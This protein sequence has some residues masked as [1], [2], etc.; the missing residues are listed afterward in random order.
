MVL[1]ALLLALY[2]DREANGK[3]ALE[4]WRDEVTAVR[5]IAADLNAVNQG[6]KKALGAAVHGSLERFGGVDQPVLVTEALV[7]AAMAAQ[8]FPSEDKQRRIDKLTR[9]NQHLALIQG[10]LWTAIAALLVVLLITL[11]FLQRLRRSRKEIQ[12]LNVSLD[13]QVQARTAEL[14]QQASYLRTLIDTLPVAVWLKDAEGRYLAVNATHNSLNGQTE[15]QMIGQT[16][17]EL[18]PGPI[19]ERLGEADLEVMATRQRLSTETV[20]PDQSGVPL[21]REIDKAP[22]LDEDGTLLGT[23]GVSH[24]ISER[25][26]AE[27]KLKQA[28]EFSEGVINA[29]PDL[30]F[31]M[32]ING[33]YLNVW[34]HTP[35]LLAGQ[36][37]MLLGKTVNEVLSPESAE[38]FM[39]TLSEAESDGLSFGKVIRNDLPQGERWFELSVSK[40]QGGTDSESTFLVLSRDIT[41]RIRLETELLDSRNFLDR[42]IDAVP[43]PIFVKDRKH[44]WVLLNEAY[45]KLSGQQREVLLGKSDY[46]FFP[47]EEAEVFWEKD[48]LVFESGEINLNEERFTSVHGKQHFIQTKKTPFI[49]ADGRKMLVGV[50]RDIT[51]RKSYEEAREAALEEARLLARSRSEF[52]AKMSHELR[53]PLNSILGFAQVLIQDR[54]L[55]EEY[56]S[57][58]SIIQ[59]SGE[60][61]LT[62]INDILDLAKS[63]AGRTEL[64]TS[65]VPTTYFLQTITDMVR[66]KAEEKGIALVTEFAADLPEMIHID[67]MRLHKILFNLLSNAVKFTEQGEVTLQVDFVA[68]KTMAICVRDT[69][70]GIPADRLETIFQPFEQA[71]DERYRFS[72]TGL[73]LAICRELVRL[74]GGEIQ[75][76][77]KPGQGSRFR[78]EIEIG[79]GSLPEHEVDA[80]RTI[81][82][83]QG[84]PKTLLVVDDLTWNRMVVRDM[85]TPYGFSIIEAVDGSDGLEKLQSNRPDLVLVDI[86]MPGMDGLEVT[87]RLRE[88]PG[89]SMTPVIAVSASVADEDHEAC[90]AA[91]ADAFL[92]NP[93]DLQRTLKQVG[94]LLRLEWRYE[95]NEQ[96]G[97]DEEPLQAP[98]REQLEALAWLAEIGDMHGI[99]ERVGQLYTIEPG[100]GRFCQRLRS[101]ASGYQSKAVSAFIRQYLDGEGA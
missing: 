93:L 59:E 92:S 96:D 91:G 77:S 6:D 98:D 28:L 41:E 14:R 80:S 27:R 70:L 5:L 61:L 88:M 3:P 17:E 56:R 82:G 97:S 20:I 99:I 49:A 90:L 73:G 24:D 43:D 1:P 2:S 63:E 46:D 16:D 87:R 42:L 11:A 75:V 58:V 18:W 76:E 85:L 68:P 9:H 12:A 36:K 89:L 54:G 21:W 47:R 95:S 31:E 19:G 32:D 65:D 94:K 78:F 81:C 55:D 34:T 52:L 71:G 26:E 48:E 7:R 13:Q 38:T 72:G 83:Y 100:C 62:L 67:E 50:I 8:R 57:K 10:W 84:E 23:V 37:E 60:H 64:D 39:E 35:E 51:D 29:I 15:D 33:R 69:G 86:N 25:K 101:L 4:A 66:V 53:S 22:V 40:K 74:M 45:C 79:V 30:L 44:R